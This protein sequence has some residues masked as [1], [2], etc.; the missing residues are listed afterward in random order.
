MSSFIRS[1]IMFASALFLVA[2]SLVYPLRQ[3]IAQLQEQRPYSIIDTSGYHSTPSP[4]LFII[5][6]ELNNLVATQTNN[7]VSTNAYYDIIFKTSES[8]S[9]GSIE[10]DF[11][12]DTDISNARLIEV[13]GISNEGT[14]NIMGQSIIYEVSKAH[15]IRPDTEIRLEFANIINPSNDGISG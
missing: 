11:P 14:I 1:T 10:I 8:G 15:Q 2:S 5:Q 7:L 6:T 13:S 12:V 4:S 9:I 3:A